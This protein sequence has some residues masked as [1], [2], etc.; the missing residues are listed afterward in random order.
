MRGEEAADCAAT[1][2]QNFLHASI[3]R[4]DTALAVDTRA[5]DGE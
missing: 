2:D 1:Y 4:S 5:S 3:H